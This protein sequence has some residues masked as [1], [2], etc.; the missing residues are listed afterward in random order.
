[1]EVSGAHANDS[2]YFS[3]LL[4]A[5]VQSGFQIKEVSADKGYD[6]FNNRRL[7]LVKGAI[8]Y[9]PH[10]EVVYNLKE[11]SELWKRMYYFY[12]FKEAEFKQHYH[13]RS[14][15]E[16][17]FSMIKAK[18][19]ERIRSKTNVSQTNE[20]LCKVLCHNLCCLIQ[21]MYELGVD[22]DFRSEG[23]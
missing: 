14:N 19:G 15:V 13:K 23:Q 9:I 21:S 17:V 20:V 2:P 18:F 7:T 8:P 16:T 4:D 1:M 22:V 12:K 11:K 10:R 6:S 5:T 3:P